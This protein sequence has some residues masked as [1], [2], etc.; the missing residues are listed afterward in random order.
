MRLVP[1]LFPC[2]LGR[3]EKGSYAVG[4][5][6]GAPDVILDALEAEGVR[7][8]RPVAV[9][10]QTP[11]AA[12]PEDAPL[13]FDAPLAR[14]LEAL[15]DVVE[16]VNAEANFP[17]VLGGDHCGLM[18]H[19]LGN[20]RRHKAGI[21]LAVLSDAYLDLEAPAPPVFEDN[22]RLRQDP[23]VT[24][25]GDAQRMVLA[26]ALKMLPPDTAVGAA[27][28]ASAVARNQTSVVGVRGARSAQVKAHERQAKI[29]VWDM[30]RLEF[31]GESAYRSMLTRHLSM[32]PIVL[33]IDV[34]GLDPDMM[35]ASRDAPPDGLDWTFLKRTLEQCVPHVD[36]I[37]GLD[38]C[39]LDH[40]ADD[41]HQGGLTRFAESIAPFLKKLTR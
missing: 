12:D 33:S 23:E 10:V 40:T 5:G 7:M 19:V 41:A 22:K 11:E 26:G 15:A 17:L 31:D 24:S 38:I 18:G 2:D 21:G 30:E 6:R 4:G 8:A 28:A 9:P 13:K 39:A 20:S 36:R 37:L 29:E 32:G 1:I 3:S 34:T 35:T 16:Q 14:A 25:T 27:M